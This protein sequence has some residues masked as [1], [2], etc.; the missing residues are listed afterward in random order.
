[1]SIRRFTPTRQPAPVP[2][3][4]VLGL[5]SKDEF[6][7]AK[8]IHDGFSTATVSRLAKSL[9]LPDS[10]VL[11]YTGIPESTFHTRKRQGKPLSPDESSRVYRIAKV[12]A[13]A[14]EFFEGNQEAARR[15][16]ANPKT[17]LGG[18]TP[19]EFARTPEGSDYVVKLL[20]RM[21]HGVIS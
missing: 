12:T 20:T 1:M 8:S 14:E 10:R 9:G 15:W 16:L 3:A 11:G 5:R 13:A 2:G 4:R 7:V 6:Q 21:A 19:L 17:A 18:A